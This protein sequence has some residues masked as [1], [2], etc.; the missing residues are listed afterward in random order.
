MPQPGLEF[1]MTVNAAQFDGGLR[2]ATRL[3]QDTARRVQRSGVTMQ[4]GFN[5][6][7][8]GARNFGQ[9]AQQ[10][11][12][13]AGDFFTQVASGQSPLRAFI[14]QGTQFAGVFGPLG[15]VIGAAGAAVGALAVALFDTEDASDSASGA[16]ERTG[17]TISGL[18]GLVRD[19]EGAARAYSEA[20]AA[21]ASVQTDASNSIVADTKREFEAKRDLLELEI[22]RQRAALADRRT[23][24]A[25]REAEL[26]AIPTFDDRLEEAAARAGRALSE[27]EVAGLSRRFGPDSDAEFERRAAPIRDAIK[28]L[29]AQAVLAEVAIK[30]AEEAASSEFTVLAKRD[31]PSGGGSS[32]GGTARSDGQRDPF[33]AAVTGAQERIT[34]LIQERNEIGLTAAEVTLLRI[35][36]EATRIESDLLSAARREGGT[37]TAEEAA[38]V[39][40]LSAQYRQVAVAALEARETQI[41]VSEAQREASEVAEANAAALAGVTNVFTNAI[42]Q[43][44]SFGEALKNVG[45]QLANLLA[46]AI[47]GQ[48][49]LAQ[50]LSGVGGVGGGG[51]NGGILLGIGRAI[52]TLI[53]GLFADGAAFSGGRVVPFAGGGV[54]NSPTTFPMT[55]GQIGLMGEAGP[56]AIMPLKRVNGKL[57]VAATGGGSSVVINHSIN[58]AGDATP[59]TVRLIDAKLQA[60]EARI[61]RAIPAVATNA[62]MR[63]PGMR[64]AFS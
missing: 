8:L 47:A 60:S 40:A 6:G 46:Q 14:Q 48:G 2:Q 26:A 41:A 57:G 55:G 51:G 35:E 10:A 23:E 61:I 3:A 12:F 53:G 9:V 62:A 39:A 56:E 15:A 5:Q 58:I 13:Q 59:Q 7:A 44:D 4:R 16:L 28:E 30:K 29:R 43:A 42:A 18:D 54:V 38:Q 36:Y 52:G 11:G 64:A 27:G 19:L 63:N 32:G 37:V 1:V 31:A 45:L 33:S 49:P 17:G 25:G 22:K 21:T 20:I 50:L 24:I 34:A